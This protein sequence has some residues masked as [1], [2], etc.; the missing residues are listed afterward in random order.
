[1]AASIGGTV[2]YLMETKQ[3]ELYELPP[4]AKL[5]LKILEEEG[6]LTQG[7]IATETMLAPRTVRHALDSLSGLG[8]V[9]ESVYFPDARK[10]LY[11]VSLSRGDLDTT[12]ADSGETHADV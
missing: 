12:R 3:S 1:M 4:S 6:K 9:Q 5:V 8:I 10:S 2:S 11:S 7:E